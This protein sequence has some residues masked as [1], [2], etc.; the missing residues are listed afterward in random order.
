[1]LQLEEFVRPERYYFGDFIEDE[2][3]L[4]HCIAETIELFNVVEI[5]LDLQICA[6][7]DSVSLTPIAYRTKWL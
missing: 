1:M 6:L 2:G 7:A 4:E 3:L 5:L